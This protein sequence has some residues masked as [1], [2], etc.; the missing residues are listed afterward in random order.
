MYGRLLCWKTEKSRALIHHHLQKPEALI[1]DWGE[2]NA[3]SLRR[4]VQQQYVV[5]TVAVA[6]R[7]QPTC[8]DIT[9]HMQTAELIIWPFMTTSFSASKLVINLWCLEA[10]C[11]C[12]RAKITS[13][14]EWKAGVYFAYWSRVFVASREIPGGVSNNL[15]ADSFRHGGRW[16]LD[17][18]ANARWPSWRK[19][20]RAH[21]RVSD[22]SIWGKILICCWFYG[23]SHFG[24][25]VTRAC[26]RARNGLKQMQPSP[27]LCLYVNREL[28]LPQITQF[29]L[30]VLT[31]GAY[32]SSQ[33]ISC[34]LFS[35]FCR[36]LVCRDT[37]FEID[38][39][40]QCCQRKFNRLWGK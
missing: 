12:M 32:L 36:I 29:P 15:L 21:G 27:M 24:M 35:T 13:W 37:I 17:E 22:G 26:P 20:S 30:F 4:V 11:G 8:D 18:N 34:P 23:T 31:I 5:L 33:V 9:F 14:M 25:L 16:G 6:C 40:W 28:L 38:N 2:L 39:E 1:Y 7:G 10:F 3:V 19:Y